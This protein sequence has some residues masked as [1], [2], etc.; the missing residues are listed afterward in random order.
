MEDV[1]PWQWDA[2]AQSPLIRRGEQTGWGG[3]EADTMTLGRRALP[4]ERRK[5]RRGAKEWFFC[6]SIAIW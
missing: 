6:R 4:P 3:L 1:L 5:Y 2:Y